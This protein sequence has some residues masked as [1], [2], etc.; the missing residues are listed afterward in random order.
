METEGPYERHKHR[1]ME[2]SGGQQQRTAIA[3]ALINR[4]KII[5]ADEP[6]GNLDSK[7]G[8]D[9]LDLLSRMNRQFGVTILMVTHSEE[10]ISY[11]SRVILLKDGRICE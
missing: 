9:V 6:V 11:G 3:R 1:P 5:F 8:K 10:S 7:S 2:L 4:P